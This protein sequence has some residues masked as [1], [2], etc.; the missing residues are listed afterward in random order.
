MK[1][2]ENLLSEPSN[3]LLESSKPLLTINIFLSSVDL[4]AI[5]STTILL[6]RKPSIEY[7]IVV[8]I[9]LS[10]VDTLSTSKRLAIEPL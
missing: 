8:V 5:I 9:S 10:K 4:L 7:T 2:R 3:L 6:S 1:I